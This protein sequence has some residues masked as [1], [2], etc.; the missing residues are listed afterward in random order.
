[1]QSPTSSPDYQ[2]TTYRPN[3]HDKLLDQDNM[4]L[5][6]DFD[7]RCHHIKGLSDNSPKGMDGP[8][9]PSREVYGPPERPPV[10]PKV[11]LILP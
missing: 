3:E 5:K 1:M 6:K 4:D 8:P 7:F 2:K 11:N 9:E 10:S